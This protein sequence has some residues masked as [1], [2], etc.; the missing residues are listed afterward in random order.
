MWKCPALWHLQRFIPRK[1]HASSGGWLPF[2]WNYFLWEWPTVGGRFPGG[3]MCWSVETSLKISQR[4]VPRRRRRARGEED[5]CSRWALPD[6]LGE[7]KDADQHLEEFGFGVGWGGARFGGYESPQKIPVTPRNGSC[8]MLDIGAGLSESVGPE[9]NSGWRGIDS[10]CHF[11]HIFFYFFIFYFW[12]SFSFR[13]PRVRA[14]CLI[15][16]NGSAS[17]HP[18]WWITVFS[19]WW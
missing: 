1:P 4:R 7:W 15:C 8:Q 6:R 10:V 2:D 13:I 17:A 12:S 14:G 5:A 18:C 11:G 16:Q 9:P 3:T 19:S